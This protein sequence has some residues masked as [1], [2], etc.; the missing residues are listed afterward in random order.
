MSAPKP[1]QHMVTGA[2]RQRVLDI[3][4]EAG[5]VDEVPVGE[6]TGWVYTL[7]GA[8]AAYIM[9]GMMSEKQQ[10]LT[11]AY[12]RTDPPFTDTIISEYMSTIG[13]KGGKAVV[14]SGKHRANMAKARAAKQ[15]KRDE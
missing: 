15:R 6:R 8:I 14:A 7:D 10:A 11:M 2:E 4:V 12:A 9:L 13:R 5:L 3:L 1:I